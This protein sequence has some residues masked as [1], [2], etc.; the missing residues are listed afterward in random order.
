MTDQQ[1]RQWIADKS[2]RGTSTSVDIVAISAHEHDPLEVANE[3][4]KQASMVTRQVRIPSNDSSCSPSEKISSSLYS[5][6]LR[7][8]KSRPRS[9]TCATT[10]HKRQPRSSVHAR[11]CGQCGSPRS[12]ISSAAPATVASR[13]GRNQPRARR[14]VTRLACLLIRRCILQ[15][16]PFHSH[17]R[18]RTLRIHSS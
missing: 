4:A 10:S 16:Y 12:R 6:M 8:R 18:L 7:G 1:L 14:A 11:S 17:Q 15:A 9:S 3:S 5:S 2:M 13:S